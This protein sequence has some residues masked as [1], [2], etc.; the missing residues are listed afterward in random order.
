[1]TPG[2][3]HTGRPGMHRE[4]L[5]FMPAVVEVLESP[6]S[7]Y[8]LAMFWCCVSLV[9][10]ALLLMIFGR[11]DIVSTGR[12]GAIPPGNVVHVQSERTGRIQA[13]HVADGDRVRAESIVLELDQR[14]ASAEFGAIQASLDAAKARR[15]RYQAML[16]WLEH[17]EDTDPDS[18]GQALADM[19]GGGTEQLA[20]FRRTARV[21]LSH[22]KIETVREKKLALVGDERRTASEEID[23]LSE[24]ILTLK[25][26][27]AKAAA[28]L[29]V[30]TIRASVSGTLVQVES[31]MPGT[32][33][34]PA[35]TLFQI[36]PDDSII[37]FEARIP[38]SEIGHVLPGDVCVVKL[39]A[40]P[41]TKWGRISSKLSYV[42][43]TSITDEQ[44]NS[45][46]VVRCALGQ[47]PQ[48]MVDAQVKLSSGMSGSLEVTTGNRSILFY[49]FSPFVESLGRSFRER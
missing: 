31:C 32:V 23:R 40:F 47:L 26:D 33:V 42:G 8:A 24:R 28:E 10:L 11:V 18:Q 34:T 38:T 17:W 4:D 9:V 35:Q 12:G 27:A 29:S 19:P 30:S 49:L 36:V 15:A 2:L 46:F 39:D 13:L 21:L 44:K 16:D 3:P 41:F 45:Y 5:S 22:F 37:Q 48:A 1:M 43:A 25:Q 14:A 7:P 20:V 6:P